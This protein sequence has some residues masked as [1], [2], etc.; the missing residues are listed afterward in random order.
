MEK[1]TG[2]FPAILLGAIPYAF[3]PSIGEIDAQ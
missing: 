1:I 2:N 3:F